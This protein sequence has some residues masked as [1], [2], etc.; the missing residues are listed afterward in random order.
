VVR[1]LVGDLI[2]SGH[3]AIRRP[4]YHRDHSIDMIERVIRGVEALR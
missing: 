3:L 4:E 1:I 2:A